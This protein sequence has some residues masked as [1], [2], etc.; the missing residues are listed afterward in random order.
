MK[1]FEELNFLKPSSH[2]GFRQMYAVTQC[3]LHFKLLYKF[4]VLLLS[5]EGGRPT[6]KFSINCKSQINY[7]V[8]T[9]D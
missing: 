9:D 5:N 1:K 8:L 3:P 6:S 2:A 4:F 7:L